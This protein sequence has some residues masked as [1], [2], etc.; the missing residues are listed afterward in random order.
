[1]AQ[2]HM[3]EAEVAKDFAAVLEKVRQG[4]EVVVE[5]DHRPVAIIRT[6]QGPGRSIDECIVLAKA[7]ETRLGFAPVPDA[8]FAQDVQSAIDAHREPLNPPSW[9]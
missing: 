6:P 3:S 2:V 8:E 5:Q 1:M 9:D 7:Y 4:T